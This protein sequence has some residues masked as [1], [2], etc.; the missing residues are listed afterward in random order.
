MEQEVQTQQMASDAAKKQEERMIQKGQ[1]LLRAYLN[2]GSDSLV[3]YSQ[4]EIVKE[5]E[6]LKFEA[7]T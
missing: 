2:G 7:D 6:D 1:S 4:D 3:Y 5:L